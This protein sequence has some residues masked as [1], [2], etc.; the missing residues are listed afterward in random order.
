[1]STFTTH[2]NLEK[3]DYLS[4]RF[5]IP[6]NRNLDDLD[7]I[8]YILQ[9]SVDNPVPVAY[10]DYSPQ[11]VAP[12]YLEGRIFYDGNT[13]SLSYYNDQDMKLDI[14]MEEIIRVYND[15][16]V[17]IPN[18]TPV[19]VVPG[20]VTNGVPH[21][22]LAS[23]DTYPHANV[24]GLTTHI[25]NPGQEGFITHAGIVGGDFSAYALGDRLFL[26]DTVPGEMIP[27]SAG[28]PD[29]VTI[30]GQVTDNG[31]DGK[32]IVK[33]TS[34]V[35][36]PTVVGYL[37]DGAVPA[38]ITTTP[39]DIDNYTSSG[40]I[41]SF[42]DPLLGYVGVPTSGIYRVT[43]NMAL[44]IGTPENTLKE[45]DVEIRKTDE[46][47]IHTF[48]QSLPKNAESASVSLSAPF[49][50][51]AGETFKIVVYSDITIAGVTAN[52]MAFDIESINI[53]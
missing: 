48:R 8:V 15:T 21:V 50:G 4:A 26:S 25:I 37:N 33:I 41:V 17:A 38:S 19:Y 13:H 5:D 35:E 34:L 40:N 10:S 44:L 6:Y 39:V 16:L 49:S 3:P 32:M 52:L 30:L 2:Y 22:E 24:P 28:L 23:A 11:L 51:V 43:I 47:V 36:V 31:T 7:G 12:T 20:V 9:Q 1:M 53:R 14:G 46:T 42:I 18:A 27:E 29:I 45:L